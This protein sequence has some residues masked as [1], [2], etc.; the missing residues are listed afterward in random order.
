MK[1]KTV[2]T[3]NGYKIN[4]LKKL[5]RNSIFCV[6]LGLLSMNINHLVSLRVKTFHHQSTGVHLDLVTKLIKS[7]I[8][9]SY[10]GDPRSCQ[11]APILFAFLL[12]LFLLWD[13][14]WAP[15]TSKACQKLCL[16]KVKT[17]CQVCTAV[18][19]H[20]KAIMTASQWQKLSMMST[21]WLFWIFRNIERK[22]MKSIQYKLEL[23]NL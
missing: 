9:L 8:F 1:K 19:W 20:G 2:Y 15:L 14:P 10:F 7:D 3:V 17:V 4:N 21:M 13:E 6:I 16:V 23:F 11:S 5:T 18:N 22:T 12:I